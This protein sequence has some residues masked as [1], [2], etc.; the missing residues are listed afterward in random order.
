MSLVRYKGMSPGLFLQH[1]QELTF[2]SSTRASLEVTFLKVT[3]P[4]LWENCMFCSPEVT[5]VH[6]KRSF[7][8]EFVL[9]GK[10]L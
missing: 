2:C 10:Q 4:G 1:M 3:H 7:L 5:L 8:Q 9:G 6:N